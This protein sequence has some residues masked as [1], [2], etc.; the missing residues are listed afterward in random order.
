MLYDISPTI[1]PDTPVWPGDTPFTYRWT[2]SLA[3]GDPVNLATV[4]TTLHLGSHADAPCHVDPR[5]AGVEALPLEPFLGACR[6]VRVPSGDAVEKRHVEGLDLAAPGRLLFRTDSVRDRRV[7]A[8]RFTALAP[9]LAALL[10]GR[11][12]ALVGVDTPS[13]DPFGSAELPAHHALIG[14]GVAIL[15]G[16]VL[17]GVPEGIYELIALPLKLAGMDGSPV[18]AVLR[19]L[20]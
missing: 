2:A 15:E 3:A 11:G 13:V 1:R 10:A 4:T 12:V 14:G 19:T 5:G 18:R 8:P 9:E 20:E 17:E 7:F 16:L 6:V